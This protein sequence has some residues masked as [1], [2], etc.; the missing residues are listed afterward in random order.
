MSL[1]HISELVLPSLCWDELD[2]EADE[3]MFAALDPDMDERYEDVAAFSAALSP[4]LGNAKKGKRVLADIVNGKMEEPAAEE[5]ERVWDCLLYTSRGK[6]LVLL[7]PEEIGLPA[8]IEQNRIKAAI[9]EPLVVG[10][11]V[12]GTLKFYYRDPVSYTHLDVYKRQAYLR[13]RLTV[14]RQREI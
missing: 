5:P 6:T 12:E 11:R 1:I 14:L 13:T 8:P 10:G 3:V 9:V 2:A 7:T 4:Y